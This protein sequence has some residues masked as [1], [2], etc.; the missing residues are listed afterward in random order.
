MMSFPIVILLPN[1]AIIL[2]TTIITLL[3]SKNLML[4]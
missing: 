1:C 2:K 4:L 3:C